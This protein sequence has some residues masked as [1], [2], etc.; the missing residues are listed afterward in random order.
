MPLPWQADLA[1][2]VISG[3]CTLGAI[4]GGIGSGKSAALVTLADAL[5]ETRPGACIVLGMDTWPRLK[6]VHQP[7]YQALCPA[8][9]WVASSRWYRYPNGS[10]VRLR[11]LDQ[12]PGAAA[13]TSP[14]EGGNIHAVILDEAQALR[15]DVLDLATSRARID[16]KDV[17]GVQRPALVVACGIPVEPAWWVDRVRQVGGRVWLPVTAENVAHLG[18]GYLERQR[19][20]LSTR[21][22][23]AL[24]ENRPLPPEGR[25]YYTWD[26]AD[27]PFGCVLRRWRYR[28]EMRTA[29]SV[30]FGLR[31]PAVLIAA[32]DEDLGAWVV[33]DELAPDEILT[34][35]LARQITRRAVPRRVWAPGDRR[36]P[37]DILVA[38]PA[39]G[40]RSSQTG[41]SDLDILSAGVGMPATVER[42]PARR[43]VRAGVTRVCLAL[44]R[45]RLLV[46]GSLFDRGLRAPRG[47]RTLA[48]AISGYAY[49]PRGGDQ[50]AKD[51]VYDHHADALRYLVRHVLWHA[52]PLDGRLLAATAEH[53]SPVAGVM[54]DPR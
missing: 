7:L 41:Q 40:A 53:W 37:L 24:I 15:P 22:Y 21:D 47:D 16:V 35:D 2:E 54:Q 51:G 26:P 28:P 32:L 4:R 42:D 31:R 8:A 27:H 1:R 45:R 19:A 33:V 25:V 11:H 18:A 30:D 10:Q 39:G 50:P 20:V 13:G 29:A 52:H 3:R 44:E 38:D 49:P 17:T 48:R 9:D 36:Y 34:P 12:P 14:L 6:D 46:E 5:A 43:E 23:A